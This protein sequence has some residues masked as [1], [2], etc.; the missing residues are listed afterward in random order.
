MDSTADPPADRI[1]VSCRRWP[2]RLT[3]IRRRCDLIRKSWML[4]ATVRLFEFAVD[5]DY[6]AV[7]AGILKRLGWQRGADIIV[8]CGAG[9]RRRN[10]QPAE[11][12]L[13]HSFWR[14]WIFLINCRGVNGFLT[15]IFEILFLLQRD[16]IRFAVA[17]TENL[18]SLWSNQSILRSDEIWLPE[19][20]LGGVKR[21]AVRSR[22]CLGESL[23]V[24]YLAQGFRPAVRRTE[25]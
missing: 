23:P 5:D 21:R 18:T 2:G 15:R 17:L 7:A 8:A 11:L 13:S 6:P 16:G 25:K 22:G 12:S 20:K 19:R 3:D 14:E 10:L 1:C 4:P 24:N 9:L